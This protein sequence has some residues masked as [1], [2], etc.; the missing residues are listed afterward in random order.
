MDGYVYLSMAEDKTCGVGWWNWFASKVP[1]EKTDDDG[2]RP[3]PSPSVSP[4]PSLP[5]TSAAPSVSPA[6]SAAPAS[7]SRPTPTPSPW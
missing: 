5:P 2:S 1:S 7:N 3:T 6:P 4:A